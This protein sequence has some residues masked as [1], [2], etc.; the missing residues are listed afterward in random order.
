[1]EKD[2]TF[3]S[4]HN[5]LLIPHGK[6]RG[7][8]TVHLDLLRRG[9]RLGI[10]WSD[11]AFTPSHRICRIS[12]YCHSSSK[13]VCLKMLC[14]PLYPMVLLIILPFLN[15][16]F[17]GNINPTFSGPNPNQLL[18]F[19]SPWHRLHSV[20]VSCFFP[21]LQLFPLWTASLPFRKHR[22]LKRDLSH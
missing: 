9:I 14:T 21:W 13:W 5:G 2:K 8:W 15:G 1:M 12:S 4:P 19:L 20:F 17:I 3:R 7:F 10:L 6:C 18:N 11:L 16:Y 22:K